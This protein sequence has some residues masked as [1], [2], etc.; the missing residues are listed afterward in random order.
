MSGWML[1]WLLGCGGGGSAMP[2]AAP[3]AA[4]T[5]AQGATA[6]A[7]APAVVP[8]PTLPASGSDAPTTAAPT[9]AA[10]APDSP[11]ARSAQALAQPLSFEFELPAVRQTSAGVYDA[12]GKLVRTLWRGARLGPGRHQRTWDGRRDNGTPGAAGMHTVR[13]I[14]HGIEAVWEGVIGNTSQAGWQP[15]RSYLPPQAM[16]AVGRQLHYAVGYNEAQSVLHAFD[17]DQPNRVQ[18]PIR[19]IDTFIGVALIASDG[20]RMY[21]VH[22]GGIDKGSFVFAFD[23]G[24]SQPWAFA[25]GRSLC[26]NP[27]PSGTECWPDQRYGSVLARRT[28]GQAQPTGVAVQAKGPVLAVAY[29]S[30]GLVLLMDKLSGRELGRVELPLGTQ[31]RQQLAFSPQGD[32][33]V[34][35]RDRL[36]RLTDVA[37]QPRVVATLT[38]LEQPLALA[39][40]PADDQALWVAEGGTRQQVRRFT[41]Q[42]RQTHVIG[43]IGGMRSDPEVHDDRL[44]FATGQGQ[45]HS[46]LAVDADGLLWILDSG[47][48]RMLRTT[49]EGRVIDRVAYLPHVYAATVDAGAPRRVFANFL[50]F[51]VD[52]ARP[53]SEPGAWRLKRNWWLALPPALHDERA[54]NAGFGGL[55][56]VST[57]PSGRTLALVR[58]QGRSRVVELGQDGTM[59]E[60]RV[61]DAGTST[62]T[63]PTLHPDGALVWAV[64][65]GPVQRVFRQAL[66]DPGP[67][68]GPPVWQNPQQWTEVPREAG[69][70]HHRMGT[71]TGVTPA[72]FPRSASGHLLFLQGHVALGEGLHLGAAP[73]GGRGW[74]W[75]ASP[76]GPLDGLGSFQTRLSDPNIHYG[77]NVVVSAGHDVVYGYHGEFYTDLSNGRVG[78]A[79]QFMHFHDSGLF[80]T[81]FGVPSTRS[82]LDS[83]E[84]GRSGNAFS[85]SL[86]KV[87]GRLLLHHNDESTWGG[88]HRWHLKGADDV[89]ELSGQA[90]PGSSSPLT[91]ARV[92]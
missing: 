9:T 65:D 8:T 86:L 71:Y 82:R 44:C 89:V 74:A 79:N 32:L 47:N 1:C 3:A 80:I 76:S 46:A 45:E 15:H 21:A 52:P 41:A 55:P 12:E 40:D 92:R 57:L 48:N 64:D 42:G 68:Q 29:G 38:G 77:G 31:S 39:A 53:L 88:V 30:D 67:G 5:P 54:R 73:E 59:R 4:T 33:W 60:L 35:G 84:P 10:P 18:R 56:L 11:G 23:L 85:L 63:E 37:T 26:L 69:A 50:E 62:R 49:P 13:L 20:Q 87:G 28:E 70:P 61:L 27:K 24:T 90:Q 22:T 36:W 91:L 83:V 66:Q 14:H 7:V 16:V 19:H 25:A 58:A 78:Q 34:V 17:I 81:Q 6:P 43:R 51:D 75:Q 72:R 2:G